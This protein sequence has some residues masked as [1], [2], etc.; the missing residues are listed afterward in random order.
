MN[1]GGIAYSIRGIQGNYVLSYTCAFSF[2]AVPCRRSSP[3]RSSIANQP[4]RNAKFTVKLLNE[5]N[6]RYFDRGMGYQCINSQQCSTSGTASKP[7]YFCT[8]LLS[9]DSF[10][11]LISLIASQTEL[12]TAP[13]TSTW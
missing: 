11:R 12:C 4:G 1:A 9:R 2:V 13:R 3:I 8:L 5:T 7:G 6:F 10:N